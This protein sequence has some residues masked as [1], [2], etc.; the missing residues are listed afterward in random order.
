LLFCF[1]AGARVQEKTF[2]IIPR[3]L[4]VVITANF[5]PGQIQTIES[6]KYFAPFD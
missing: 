1:I 5:V 4:P 2:F 6:M 3:R